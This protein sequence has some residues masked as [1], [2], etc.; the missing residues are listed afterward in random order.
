MEIIKNVIYVC[1]QSNYIYIYFL[2]GIA[3]QEKKH[4]STTIL[5]LS[6]FLNSVLFL[7]LSKKNF[8]VIIL[9]CGRFS[10]NIYDSHFSY[11]VFAGYQ[12]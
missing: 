12:I 9:C 6:I 7:K 10:Q 11:F 1:I 4:A 5:Y 2:N 3:F 8:S